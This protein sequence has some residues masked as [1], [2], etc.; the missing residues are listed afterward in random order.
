MEFGKAVCGVFL[1]LIQ[2]PITQK[3]VQSQGADES[4]TV[5]LKS[6]SSYVWVPMLIK[7]KGGKPATDAEIGEVSLFD[8]GN[9]EKVTHIDTQGLPVSIVV[10]MQTGNS[11]A[12]YLH[13]YVNL[14]AMI[15]DMVGSSVREITL[16][17][18]DSRIKEIW[19]FPT[20]SD[21]VDWALTHQLSGDRGAAI[22]DAL[23][24]GVGQLQDEP[25]RF[26]RIVILISQSGDVGSSTSSHSLVEQL[27]TSS[28]IVYSLIFQGEKPHTIR[29]HARNAKPIAAS[30]L[31]RSERA[32]DQQTAQTASALT[33]GTSRQFKTEEDFDSA[34]IQI[35]SD[36]H[37][38]ITLGFQPSRHDG[39]FHQIELRSNDRK[40][41][42]TA[43]QGYWFAPSQQP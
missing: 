38:G 1:L 41:D 13:S 21:G 19:H 28:T 29:E 24:F 23:A 35:L 2:S 31:E 4:R 30:A 32:L 43:R 3:Y 7:D 36:F 9:S 33:G 26:R 6:D 15:S 27:G 16:V 12:N 10:L 40:L 11:A 39:G 42:V 18:F 17:T 20:K 22:K 34:M 5:I 14:P 37:N 25:G 8:N